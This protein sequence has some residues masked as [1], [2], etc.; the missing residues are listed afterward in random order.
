MGRNQR[1]ESAATGV[2]T[3]TY[4]TA[5]ATIANPTATAPA[6]CAAMT[7]SAVG[8]LVATNNGWGASSEANFDAVHTAIDQAA[9]DVAA[10]KTAIDANNAQI[11][12]LI[13]DN[14]D[15]RKA[16]TSIIDVM[17]EAGIVT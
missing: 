5:D 9:T 17:Q 12:A 8:D 4:S 15:L 7:L 3:Q 16:I 14:L 2:F 11:D 1:D 10:L 13:A 6:A